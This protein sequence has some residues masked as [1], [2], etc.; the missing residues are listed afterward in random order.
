MLSLVR[1]NC[2]DGITLRFLEGAASYNG[3]GSVEAEDAVDSLA[4]TELVGW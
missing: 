1:L 2:I 3:D 4:D